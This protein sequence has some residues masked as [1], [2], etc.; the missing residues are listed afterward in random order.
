MRY[1]VLAPLLLS[2][3]AMA[4]SED[5]Q[6]LPTASPSRTV[7]IGGVVDWK[8]NFPGSA[9]RGRGFF[10]LIAVWNAGERMPVETPDESFGINFIGDDEGVS[11]GVALTSS[12]RRRRNDVGLDVRNVGFGVEVGGFA[13]AWVGDNLRLRGEVR[14]GIG[15]HQSQTADVAADFVLRT[16]D[17]NLLVTAGPRVRWG[18]GGYHRRY[19]GVSAEEVLANGLPQ[20]RPDSG[21]YA[22]GG[23]ASAHVHVT[24]AIGVYAYGGYDRLTGDAARSPIVT[25]VGDRDQFSFG[26]GF[27]YRFQVTR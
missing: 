3:P 15:G 20:F 13:Q 4:Q 1:L 12:P 18:S 14:Q 24:R 9:D 10:P 6:A 23:V 17:D 25:S 26:A 5:Y 21:V 27:S 11:A 2:A 19:F 22:Y 8:P 7:L 16:A